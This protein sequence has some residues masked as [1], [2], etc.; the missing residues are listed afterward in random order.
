[1]AVTVRINRSVV[2]SLTSAGGPIGRQLYQTGLRV[3][4]RA[5]RNCPVDTGRLR[6]SIQTTAPFFENGMPTVSV[7][8]NVNYAIFVHN[9]TRY[10]RGRPFLT[11]ALEAEI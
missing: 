8:T 6:S 11:D 2:R 4:S 3:Q 1:M 10:M 7:G 9:G 5:K